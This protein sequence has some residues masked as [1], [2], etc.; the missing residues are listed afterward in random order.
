M[1][2]IDLESY[3]KRLETDDD[4]I[5]ITT[6]VDPY[7]EVTL[8]QHRVMAE[9][10]K[11]LLFENVKGSPYRLV[12]NLYGSDKRLLTL[13]GK[14]PEQIGEELLSLSE[15][16][17]PP[18]LGALWEKK[19][20][21]FNV[22]NSRLRTVGNGPILDRVTEPPNLDE[23]PCLTC[24]PLDGGPFFTLPL[25]HTICPV[26]GKGNLG[27]YRMQRYDK[28]AT[29]MHWQI[30]KGGGFHFA[31]AVK[32]GI[33]F[34]VSVI[35]GGPP[36]LTISAIAPLPEGID[37]RLLA[38]YLLGGPLDVI[39]RPSDH[40]IPAQAD[41][42][43]EGT[44]ESGDMRKEGPFG[45]HLGHY[46][47]SA[48]FPVFRV[49]RVLS[50]KNA[51]YPATVVGK[52]PQEDLYIGNALQ[53]M[54]VPLLKIIHKGITDLWSY[55][56]TGFHPLAVAS[57]KERYEHEGLKH[58]LSILG[59]G[60]LSLTKTLI[61]ISEGR[62]VKDFQKVSEELWRN[63]DKERLTLLSPTAQD[64]LDFTGPH[65]NLGSRLILVA[66]EKSSGPV[67]S[68]MPPPLPDCP[69]AIHSSIADLKRLGPAILI[70][71]VRKN[72]AEDEG[73]RTELIKAL[74]NSKPSSEY[75]FHVLVSEDVN[76]HDEM[77]TL[78]GWF[79]RFD[80]FKDL[81]PKSREISGNKLILNFPVTIDSQWKK[82]YRKP[83]EFD[84]DTIKLVDRKWKSYGID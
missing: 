36:V 50:R 55:P 46:S 32:K 83:V 61:I 20:T 42:V 53:K 24:W 82:G 69:S 7:L 31:E 2:F 60:Q 21:I 63:L 12:S 62:N 25:V 77:S 11:A 81:H 52:P 1:S 3:I 72:S 40:K 74:Q 23:L 5:R 59:E 70:V 56:E 64:T 68:H 67:R 51:I 26:T 27:I 14:E 29:G 4:L 15:E 79:T 48:H 9:R 6:E 10:G 76:I 43:L 58:A 16:L 8:I 54:F 33:T 71:K 57:V 84:D 38:S 75:L 17:M 66:T 65:I 73:A 34:P 35:L 13:L 22:A 30:E 41:F 19:N 44:I 18:T 80:P 78:W 37:E 45:D 47:H 49:K 28:A 39:S